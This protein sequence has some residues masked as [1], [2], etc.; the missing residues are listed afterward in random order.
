MGR[1]AKGKAAR[2]MGALPAD[3]KLKFVRL[4]QMRFLWLKA[5]WA[6]RPPIVFPQQN[7]VADEKDEQTQKNQATDDEGVNHV[8]SALAEKL[9]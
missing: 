2:K 3:A 7:L 1:P 6:G 8:N 9:R 4:G 5:A